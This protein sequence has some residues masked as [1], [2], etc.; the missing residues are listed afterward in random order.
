[1]ARMDL[2]RSSLSDYSF[3]TAKKCFEHYYSSSLTILQEKY[4]AY[5]A[6]PEKHKALI[7]TFFEH[8]ARIRE[9]ITIN[10]QFFTQI[11]TTGM[12]MVEEESRK[13]TLLAGNVTRMTCEFVV[14]KTQQILHDVIREWSAVGISERKSVYGPILAYMEDLKK[15]TTPESIKILIPNAG[16]GR[17]VWELAKLG[18]HCDACESSAAH[19]LTTNFMIN[20]SDA[21]S[22]VTI[23]PWINKWTNHR[24]CA[25]QIQ[26]VTVPDV[27]PDL[28]RNGKQCNLVAGDF[29]NLYVDEHETYDIICTVRYINHPKKIRDYVEKVYDL[30]KPGAVW[31][32]MGPMLFHG[33]NEDSNVRVPPYELVRLHIQELGFHFEKEQLGI[34]INITYY[35][36]SMLSCTE[37]EASAEFAEKSEMIRFILIQNRAGKTRLAKW[38]MHFDDNEKQKL[39]EEVHAVVTV[40]DAKHTNFVEMRDFIDLTH[41]DTEEK[42][43]SKRSQKRKASADISFVDLTDDKTEKSK[44]ACCKCEMSIQMLLKNGAVISS[45]LCGHVFCNKCL[46]SIPTKRKSGCCPKLVLKT[47]INQLLRKTTLL[48][49]SKRLTSYLVNKIRMHEW[50]K[51]NDSVLLAEFKRG[52]FAV[53]VEK[54]PLIHSLNNNQTDQYKLLQINY[55]CL[56]KVLL[57]YKLNFDVKDTA[58]LDVVPMQSTTNDIEE[59]WTPVFALNIKNASSVGTKKDLAQALGGEFHDFRKVFLATDTSNAKLLTKMRNIFRWHNSFQN[60]PRCTARLNFKVSKASAKCPEC[61]AVYYPPVAPVAIT[62]VSTADMKYLLLVRQKHHPKRLYTAIS[63]FSELESKDSVRIRPSRKENQQAMEV[64]DLTLD[65]SSTSSSCSIVNDLQCPACFSSFEEIL[66]EGNAVMTTPC[67]HVFC[68]RCIYTVFSGK[69]SLKC[70]ICRRNI[71]ESSESLEDAVLREIAEEVGILVE[72]FQYMGISQSWPFPNNSLMCAYLAYADRSQTISIDRKELVDAR[73]FSR[74]M[75]ASAFENTQ[76]LEE[77]KEEEEEEDGPLLI[78][79]KGTIVHEMIKFWLSQKAD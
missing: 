52:N 21:N 57:E 16:L 60:C 4:S 73:W 17:L 23:Y 58:L 75:V 12:H 33:R 1:M 43:R 62:L 6:L 72:N 26:S 45:I 39:I 53:C 79:S 40:R 3:M 65:S 69:R 54:Q 19:V 38:Y 18:Y 35:N 32:N 20:H 31:I 24:N 25:E 76:N 51:S 29:L 2:H 14:G 71:T 42:R 50:M 36:Q 66:K 63:G 30:L 47:V 67:G 7:P 46:L 11:Y 22:P 44:L 56:K 64:I 9:S 78:S 41:C 8:I 13:N 70:P 5:K 74:E 48:H 59:E 49:N 10:M 55:K 15:S 37:K 61:D 77:S 28:I 34:P 68:A 27:R